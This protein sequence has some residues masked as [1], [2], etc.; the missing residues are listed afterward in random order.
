[1]EA[2][3]VDLRPFSHPSLNIAPSA[4]LLLQVC[5]SVAGYHKP[6]NLANLNQVP[7]RGEQLGQPQAQKDRGVRCRA[8][9]K[10]W[11]EL[12]SFSGQRK[13]L[14]A[15]RAARPY[16]TVVLQLKPEFRTRLGA[17]SQFFVMRERILAT[18]CKSSCLRECSHSR[19]TRNPKA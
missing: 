5:A 11:K 8:G 13:P 2:V 12:F 6:K 15:G 10:V 18:H 4:H 17:L 9:A 19:Q 1:M 16:T 3:G 14:L 7:K